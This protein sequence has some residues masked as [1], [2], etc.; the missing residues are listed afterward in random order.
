MGLNG[1]EILLN[2]IK[3]A[4]WSKYLDR[5][6]NN[7]SSMMPYLTDAIIHTRR[8]LR[9]KIL[10]IKPTDKVKI[11]EA[12]SEYFYALHDFYKEYI[13]INELMSR[14]ATVADVKIAGF[15][16]FYVRRKPLFD[17]VT[18]NIS[19]DK[20]ES[21]TKENLSDFFDSAWPV[22]LFEVNSPLHEKKKMHLIKND[23][24][25]NEKDWYS[26]K[27]A[28][29]QYII[30]RSGESNECRIVVLFYYYDNKKKQIYFYTLSPDEKEYRYFEYPVK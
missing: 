5:I 15:L 2:A 7:K 30:R 6:Q 22:I 1:Q 26:K 29:G 19:V 3:E 18:G 20:L 11:R 14:L 16:H 21:I 9:T 10:T 23:T 24:S 27:V 25:I 28:E 13:K 12:Y 17:K 8:E 4:D